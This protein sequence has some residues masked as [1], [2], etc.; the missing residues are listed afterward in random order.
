MKNFGSFFEQVTGP[1][2]DLPAKPLGY[3]EGYR[4]RAG[5]EPGSEAGLVQPGRL[6]REGGYGHHDGDTEQEPAREAEDAA[7]QAIEEAEADHRDRFAGQA[8]GE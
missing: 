8:R 3:H 7:K 6:G 4:M 5:Q 1:S 2:A